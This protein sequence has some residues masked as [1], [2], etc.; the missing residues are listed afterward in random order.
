MKG[1]ILSG[2][3]GT[4]MRPLTHS[5]AKQLLPIANVP[6]LHRAIQQM[7]DTGI[8]DIAIIV[9]STSEQVKFSVGDGSRF[10][11][12]VTYLV[13]DQPLGLAH[14]VNIAREFLSEDDFVM[15]LGD[16]MFEDG[17]QEIVN[18]FRANKINLN[19]AAQVAVKQV[20]NPSSFGVA[21]VDSE[22]QLIS[23]EEKPTAP[24][25]DLAL[26]GTYCFTAK[27]HNAIAAINP[28]PRGE[29]EIT[30]A[31]QQLLQDEL[32]VGVSAVTGW[33]FDT[34]TPASFLE[35]NAKVLETRVS[36]SNNF[37]V[38]VSIIDPCSIDSS[39]KLS[40]CTIGPYVSIGANVSVIGSTISNSVLLDQSFVSGL[41]A[42]TNS[43]VGKRSSIKLVAH[44]V[45][46]VILGDDCDVDIGSE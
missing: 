13:Q 34:G 32:H 29:F 11:V 33:W 2:G 15:F 19:S 22:L 18:Q 1:L 4:R 42:I 23:V 44:T 7:F 6:I 37:S 45:S 46:Q 35:C 38:D 31:I 10:G 27:I 17:L 14:C 40:N 30:D 12:N 39:A 8:Q 28:S 9:G 24:K 25:S 43:I 16:N 3:S 36:R 26:V 20:P 5:V 21:V 41:G